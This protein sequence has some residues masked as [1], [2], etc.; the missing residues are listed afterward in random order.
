MAKTQTDVYPVT[1]V[2]L[3][4]SPLVLVLLSYVCVCAIFAGLLH[5]IVAGAREN[6]YPSCIVFDVKILDCQRNNKWCALFTPETLTD[7]S[8]VVMTLL[9]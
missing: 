7:A 3:E 6:M 4:L 1:G 8:A 5:L 2:W 9:L